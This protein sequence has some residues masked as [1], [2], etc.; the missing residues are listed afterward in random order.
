MSHFSRRLT[1]RD[2]KAVQVLVSYPVQSKGPSGDWECRYQIL[3]MGNDKAKVS[4]GTDSIQAIYLA[5]QYIATTL[6]SSEEYERG[7]LWWE[8]G[9]TPADLGLPVVDTVR[10][11]VERKKVQVSDI[12]LR[13]KRG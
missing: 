13:A 5:L 2:G 6:Y 3:G 9:V 7:E 8:G 10:E 4:V 1:R 11:D 12:I